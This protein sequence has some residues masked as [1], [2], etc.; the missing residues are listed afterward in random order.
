[1]Y[2][3]FAFMEY[4]VVLTN[5]GFHMAAYYDFYHHQLTVL[6]VKPPLNVQKS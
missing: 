2:T 6:E 5:M 1:M 3:A 4:L